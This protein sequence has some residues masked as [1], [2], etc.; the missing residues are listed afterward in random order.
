MDEKSARRVP[1][2]WRRAGWAASAVLGTFLAV[3]AP[4]APGRAPG[5]Y[6]TVDPLRHEAYSETIPGSKVRFDMVPIPGGTFWMGSPEGEEGRRA[7]EGPRH[8][9]RIPPFWMGKVEVTWDEFDLYYKEKPEGRRNGRP[10]PELAGKAADAITRP[11][12][13]YIDET[14]GFGHDGYPVVGISHHAAMEYCRWLSTKTGKAY[15]LPTEAEWEYACRAGTRTAWFFGDDPGRLGEH[16]W[17]ETNSG[18]STHP[19]GQKKPNPWGLYDVCGNV[20]EWCLDSYEKD[21]Y[22]SFSLFRPTVAPVKVPGRRRF[23]HAVRGGSWVDPARRCRSAARVG[24]EPAWNRSD[25]ERPPSIWWLGDA[26]FVGFRVV[27]AVEEQ[28]PLRGLRSRVT[29]ES[30]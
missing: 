19:V 12:P 4:E 3:L 26:D 29:R 13:S 28:E 24:S 10:D 25:P 11:S 2:P 5:P 30:P 7:D 20:A 14:R 15:R 17:F 23:P 27:R 16:A 22:A 9:V 21:I 18:E 1:V 8:P 6:P